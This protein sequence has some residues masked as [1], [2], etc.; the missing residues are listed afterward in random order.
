MGLPSAAI[1]HDCATPLTTWQTAVDPVT[2]DTGCV[3]PFLPCYQWHLP[4]RK[5]TSLAAQ[6]FFAES[7]EPPVACYN[8]GKVCNSHDLMHAGESPL[9]AMR[10]DARMRRLQKVLAID[11]AF[12]TKL[13][14]VDARAAEDQQLVEAR[15]AD[16]QAARD[17]F[18]KA[19]ESYHTYLKSWANAMRS[20]QDDYLANCRKFHDVTMPCERSYRDALK[21]WRSREPLPEC[22]VGVVTPY[23]PN[24]PPQG[25]LQSLLGSWAAE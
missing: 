23:E 14:S 18:N 24:R 7:P 25:W 6:A 19:F 8:K 17:E 20:L 2:P 3:P 4:F 5:H 21:D 12:L 13:N 16:F 10:L 1:A 15:A 9:S 11:P 22:A